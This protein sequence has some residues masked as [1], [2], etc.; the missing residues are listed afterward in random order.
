MASVP[1]N[2]PTPDAPA[3]TVTASATRDAQRALKALKPDDVY[4][5]PGPVTLR[6]L[7]PRRAAPQ[8]A[9]R[10]QGGV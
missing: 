7:D 2:E 9:R 6:R 3:E 8:P 1:T 10:D 4:V 5:F